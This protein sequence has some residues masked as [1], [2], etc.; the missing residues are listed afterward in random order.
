MQTNGLTERF[1]QTL[2]R[3]LTKIVN[4]SQTDWDEKINTVLM[5]RGIFE[6]YLLPLTNKPTFEEH[7][8]LLHNPTSWATQTEVLAVATYFRVPVFYYVLQYEE[9]VWGC[10]KPLI[11]LNMKHPRNELDDNPLIVVPSHCELLYYKNSHHCIVSSSDSCV[12]NDFPLVK[13][14]VVEVMIFDE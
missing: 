10:F 12:P 11:H 1:N 14:K 13:E 3:C 6:T 4:E 7:L 5:D 2:S 8:Q 9:Y